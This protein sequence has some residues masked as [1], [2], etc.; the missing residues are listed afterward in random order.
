MTFEELSVNLAGIKLSH[1]LTNGGGT[2]KR[3]E[4]MESFAKVEGVAAIEVGSITIKPRAGNPGNVYFSDGACSINS[5]GLP[6]PGWAY[7]EKNIPRM[8]ELAHTAGKPIFVNIAGETV[9]EYVKLAVA[10][11]EF[12]IDLLILN[13]SCP[14]VW[15]KSEQ[16]EILC[17]YPEEF[18]NLLIAVKSAL[19]PKSPLKLCVKLSPLY[20]N[21]LKKIAEIIMNKF[22]DIKAVIISNTFPNG[23]MADSNGKPILNKMK[24]G[25]VG[26]LALKPTA[27]GMV[28]Q[29]R[30][31]L[32]EDI[33]II[34]VGGITTGQDMADF[35]VAG[36][37]AVQ[38]ATAF[39]G[40]T[41]PAISSSH[42]YD[43]FTEI[44]AQYA[45]LKGIEI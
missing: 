25:G 5:N 44:M 10:I 27:L 3:L 40:R 22:L 41:Y 19:P 36:A 1:P 23:F 4:E 39:F 6:N 28:Y 17:Y 29:L 18:Y 33:E 9:D 32:T 7:Y 12:P 20:P 21:L 14:N 34:G 38:I 35:I 43:I 42:N 8:I 26:G 15:D 2:C 30:E 24:L 16:K 45:R 13:C 37:K 11:S 31:I